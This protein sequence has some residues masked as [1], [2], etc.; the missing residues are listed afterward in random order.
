MATVLLTGSSG[1]IGTTL[2]PGLTALGHRVVG[3]DL[4]GRGA[5]L[6]VDCTDPV[7]VDRAMAEVRPDAV[8]HLAGIP[9][10]S[11]LPDA[12]SS[13]VVSTGALLEAMRR[14]GV[15]RIAYA[16]SNHAVGRTPR[17]ALLGADVHARPDTYYGVGKVAAE[18]LL[19]LYA[20]RHGIDAVSTRIGSFL[21][22]PT[23][24]RQLSTWLSPGDTVRMYAAALT[25][26]SP[27]FAVIY[28][29]SANTRGWWDLAPGRALGYE[30]QD[31]AEQYAAEVEATPETESDRL[32]SAVVGGPYATGELD[33][34]P[35]D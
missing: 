12:L 13:H 10:E 15:P 34:P 23:T 21:D 22:R 17:T 3:L 11:S 1:A 14:H 27:G 2:T 19:H 30:P 8:I 6:A 35:F 25:A 31:D 16:S 20:D 24:R 32:E 26:P 29:V 28:G 7:A 33:R 9:T 18:A 4:P 5:D